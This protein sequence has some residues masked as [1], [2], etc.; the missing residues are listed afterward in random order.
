M[1]KLRYILFIIIFIF[2][3]NNYNITTFATPQSEESTEE[4][5]ENGSE[6][7]AEESEEAEEDTGMEW[8]QDEKTGKWFYRDKKTK[9][10]TVGWCNISDKWYYFNSTGEMQTNTQIGLYTLDEEGILI[11]D[12]SDGSVPEPHGEIVNASNYVLLNDGTDNID[13]VIE[14]IN[15]LYEKYNDGKE[16]AENDIRQVRYQYNSLN[17]SEKA[18]VNNESKLAAMENSYSIVYDYDSLYATETDALVVDDSTKRG[19]TYTFAISDNNNKT[20]IITRF[21]TDT[22]ND[23]VGDVPLITLLSPSGQDYEVEEQDTEIRVP[24]INIS[25]TW[26][27]NYV[28][29][30]ISNAE[31]GNWTI[32]T[33]L[34][35]T[36]QQKEYAGAQKEYNPI[37][38]NELASKGDADDDE[39]ETTKRRS[40]IIVLMPLI[41][42]FV[43]GAAAFI[44]IKKFPF[45]GKKET[46]QNYNNTVPQNANAAPAPAMTKEEEIEKLKQ[47][48]E[49]MNAEDDY[50]DDYYNASY[51]QHNPQ[52]EQSEQYSEEEINESVEEYDSFYY[53]SSFENGTFEEVEQPVNNNTTGNNM[54]TNKEVNE[55][56]YS[57]WEEDD[58]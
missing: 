8:Y 4:D 50:S 33:N 27:D 20:T 52:P 40:P 49:A 25:I 34:V 44:I 55:S 31:N 11:N 38:D 18:K 41:L 57:E 7:T 35:C 23:G 46:T 14:T 9:Q 10:K 28:Q 48:L 29:M 54:N 58:E 39:E 32:N 45:G 36:F 26:T 22:D 21:T 24:E 3:L 15:Q 51:V 16:I 5:A 43:F 17:L 1:R 12:L 53:D 47:E 2:S 30:D 37:P 13:K 56:N 42:V 6:N 19:T